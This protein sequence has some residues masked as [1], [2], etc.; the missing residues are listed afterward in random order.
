[1][2]LGSYLKNQLRDRLG[3]TKVV[4]HWDTEPI[5]E[6]I[7]D[8]FIESVQWKKT[9]RRIGDAPK[10]KMLQLREEKIQEYLTYRKETENPQTAKSLKEWTIEQ[11]LQKIRDIEKRYTIKPQKGEL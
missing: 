8:G 1:M 10:K 11:N 7:E 2:L 9:K 5:E 3:I 6:Y 4:D